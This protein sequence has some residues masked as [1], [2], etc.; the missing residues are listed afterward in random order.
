MI[1]SAC[2]QDSVV[3]TITTMSFVRG[4]AHDGAFRVVGKKSR[5][6]VSDLW[7]EH[8]ASQFWDL[9][10]HGYKLVVDDHNME[11]PTHTQQ[12]S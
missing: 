5:A 9:K 6:L 2:M 1:C 10:N 12:E 7:R 4:V 11:V 8:S 3:P